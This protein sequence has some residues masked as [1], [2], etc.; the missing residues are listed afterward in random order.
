MQ[1]IQVIGIV[2][3]GA[4]IIIYIFYRSYLKNIN[5]KNNRKTELKEHTHTYDYHDGSNYILKMHGNIENVHTENFDFETLSV[6]VY[7]Y[8]MLSFLFIIFIISNT[9]K[10]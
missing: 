8:V 9:F 4:A 6:I 2:N 10:K 5:K 1:K 3:M 7:I